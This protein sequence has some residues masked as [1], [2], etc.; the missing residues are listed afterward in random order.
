M[1]DEQ[2]IAG[3]LNALLE[4]IDKGMERRRKAKLDEKELAIKEQEMKGDFR[5]QEA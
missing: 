4:G 3:A 5:P 1:A 2:F